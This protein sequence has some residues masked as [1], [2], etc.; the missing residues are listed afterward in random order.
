MRKLSVLIWSARILAILAII[1]LLMFSLDAFSGSETFGRKLWGFIVHSIPALI[2]LCA[3]IVAWKY[4]IAGGAIFII[5]AIGL[6]IFWDSFKS[7]SGSLILIA[8]FFV[9][10]LLFILHGVLLR[11]SKTINQ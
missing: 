9:T 3:L 2:L 7:N 11:K 4:E 5:A 10:G 8:P 1:F 6:G